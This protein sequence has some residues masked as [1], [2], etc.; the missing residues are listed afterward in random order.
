MTTNVLNIPDVLREIAYKLRAKDIVALCRSGKKLYLNLCN[1][2]YFLKQVYL[3]YFSRHLKNF[4][5]GSVLL[6]LYEYNNI[7]DVEDDSSITEENLLKF[8]TYYG[9]DRILSAM[10]DIKEA[11]GEQ[12]EISPDY[13]IRLLD[14]DILEEDLIDV[15]NRAKIVIDNDIKTILSKIIY[16]KHYELLKL[17]LQKMNETE[18]YFDIDEIIYFVAEKDD[19]TALNIILDTSGDELNDD[20]LENIF[21]NIIPISSKEIIKVFLDRNIKLPDASIISAFRR[22]FDY[23]KFIYDN[24]SGHNHIDDVLRNILEY[25]SDYSE[26]TL[27]I[28]KFL[29]AKIDLNRSEHDFLKYATISGDLEITKLLLDEGVDPHA[30]GDDSFLAAAWVGNRNIVEYLLN[31][32]K[33]PRSSLERA[34]AQ[35]DDPII[36]KLLTDELD[37][38][39]AAKNENS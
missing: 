25:Y 19:I 35:A 39:G 23:F 22:D 8:A 10:M 24:S 30:F 34:Y 29:V 6:Q 13:F 20:E 2:E 18:G 26:E 11:K 38:F 9:F 5:P 33:Y 7:F 27:K 32:Y 12:L 4:V 37:K 31:H 36:E 15:V 17:M 3:K 28:I 1:N 14:S 21:L 16:Y